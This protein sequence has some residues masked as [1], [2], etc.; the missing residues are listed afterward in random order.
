MIARI[1]NSNLLHI[2]TALILCVECLHT[3]VAVEAEIGLDVEGDGFHRMLVYRVFFKNLL[4]D[5]CR[6]AIYQKLPSTLYVNVDEIAELTR[7]GKNAVCSMGETNVELFAE[8]S[9][10]QNVTTC[11]SVVSSSSCVLI[12][13][14]HQRY[15]Y[16]R[17]TGGYVNVTLP[18]P[19]LLLG[20]QERLKDHRVSKIN[21]CEPCVDLATKWREIPYT[22]LNGGD[23]EWSVPVG[24]SSLLTFVIYV[25]LLFTVVS[26]IFIASAI[27]VNASKNRQKED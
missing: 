22:V 8:K 25:T 20:C 18:M 2:I 7:R 12:I 3:S 27:H 4:N 16:A 21:L 23:Y 5:D 6:A 19:R 17:K 13:P 14:V 1:R 9:G 26:A 11:G 10:Q 24:N 15:Q